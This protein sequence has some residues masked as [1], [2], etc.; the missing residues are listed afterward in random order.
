[1]PI[2]YLSPSTQENNYFVSGGTE[3]QYMNLLADK[4]VPYLDA[5]G[6]RYVR[7]T[8]SM[9]A[10]SSIAASN[11]G[12]YDLHLALHSNAAP[13]GQYGTARGSVVYY[14]P[15][16]T[17]G[18]RAAEIVTDGLKEI[19]PIPNLVRAESTTA[20]GEVRR[21]NA[22]SVFL[23][24]AFHDNIYDADWIKNNLDAIAR[25]IVISL[26]EYFG[27]PFYETEQNASGTVD[28]SW[29]SL[30][31]RARPNKNAPILAQAP[32]G[33]PLS[34]INGSNGWYLVNYNGTIGYA[35]GTFITLN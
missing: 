13:E 30:N 4:M 32:D 31:I 19:Y 1:M 8:P 9:T 27:I 24:L 20:I 33:A 10:V 3:E 25:N 28:V 5:S 22:P 15:G 2:I 14:Y 18:Q 23:E 11:A 16:S 17:K 12:T 7:N 6:I 35:S 21:I 34:I 26:T 29:G